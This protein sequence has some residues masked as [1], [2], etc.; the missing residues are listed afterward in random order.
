MDTRDEKSAIYTHRYVH[1]LRQ[2]SA[3]FIISFKWSVTPKKVRASSNI[4][5]IPVL[6][7]RIDYLYG[8][9]LKFVNLNRNYKTFSLQEKHGPAHQVLRITA[10]SQGQRNQKQIK[11]LIRQCS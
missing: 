3:I 6:A 4:E 10:C 11:W 8:L 2:R 5:G 9:H 1:L 7:K